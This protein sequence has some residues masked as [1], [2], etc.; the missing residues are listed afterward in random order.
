[1]MVLSRNKLA[2]VDLLRHPTLPQTGAQ[3]TILNPTAVDQDLLKPCINDLQIQHSRP[4][5]ELH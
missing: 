4:E 1:M 5:P 3:E 2:E